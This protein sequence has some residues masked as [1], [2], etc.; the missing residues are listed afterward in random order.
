MNSAPPQTKLNDSDFQEFL[1]LQQHQAESIAQATNWQDKYRQLMQLSKQMTKFAPS[2]QHDD[3]LV[4]GCESKAWVYHRKLGNKHYFIADS[5]ARIV[6]GLIA[7]L[8][9]ACQGKTTEELQRFDARDHFHYL[10][11]EG[12]LSPSRANGL[13]ALVNTIQAAAA[14]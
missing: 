11:L 2:L 4:Q 10:G 8:L 5:E 6:K 1:Q 3:A 13:Y 12:Q 7:L 14:C 9:L